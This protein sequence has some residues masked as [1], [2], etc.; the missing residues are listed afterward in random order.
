M[1]RILILLLVLWHSLVLIAP[2]QAAE[3]ARP[4]FVIFLSDDHSLLD[5]TPYG[6][7]DVRTPNMQRLSDDGLTF[8]RAFVASPSCA[9]SRAAL[10]TGLMPARNG[11]EANHTF[12]K[13]GIASLPEVL[14]QLGYQTAAFGKVAH[15]RNDAKNHGFD[16][17]DEQHSAA[18]VAKFFA[19]RDQ[20]KPLCLFVG[21]HEPHAPWLPNDGYDLAKLD[22]PHNFVD[23][24]LAREMRARYYTDVTK[25]DTL[26]GEIRE[27]ARKN[28]PAKQTLF[29]YTSD[30]GAQWPLGKWNL[31]DAGIRVPFL[32]AWEGVIKPGTRTDA[33]IQWPD[34][35]PT[36]IE[37]A[38][39]K[40]P[41]GLDGRSFLKVLRGEKSTHREV[42]YTTHSGDG[43][44]N[45][46]PIRA[47]RTGDWKLIWNLHPEFAHTT[48]V[49]RVL[50]K[51][52]GCY[53]L[54]WYEAAK[55]NTTAAALVKR[56]HER[57][58]FEL[59]DVRSDSAEEHNLVA[60]PEQASRVKELKA[61]L[62]AWMQEQGDKRT[63]FNEPHLL[64]DRASTI[65]GQDAAAD[66]A[67]P[68]KKKKKAN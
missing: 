2:A 68:K 67:P 14:R 6:A 25:A 1:N 64:S 43:R 5:S 24:P 28:L 59:Y 61:Q 19:E 46:Y 65:P 30:H 27:L 3:V 58:E 54:S 52:S 36:L 66:T 50:S 57:P 12:K 35:L 4:N 8:N 13:E 38:G 11:A 18:F 31:Y 22:L 23:T 45:I 55:T 20:S 44:M 48:H 7:K 60:A 17:F 10:L 51:D 53:W 56:Y 15:G 42:I 37:A 21:T 26:L 33:M 16:V 39:G 40:V 63:V 62:E 9:P 47:I 34:L 49:D 41:A 32:A 29:I